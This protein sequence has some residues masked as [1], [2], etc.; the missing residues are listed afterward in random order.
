MKENHKEIAMYTLGAMVTVGF[1]AVIFVY[2]SKD[3]PDGGV[4]NL[5]LGALVAAFTTVLGYFYGSSKSS[6]D[7]TKL[8]K[9]E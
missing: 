3:T 4:M 7:K 1:F 9:P 6:H 8:L 2:M 5:L